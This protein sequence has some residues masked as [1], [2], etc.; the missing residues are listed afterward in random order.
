MASGP[1]RQH[2]ACATASHGARGYSGLS[3]QS[4]RYLEFI[5]EKSFHLEQLAQVSLTLHQGKVLL[6]VIEYVRYTPG[7]Q[8]AEIQIEW[9]APCPVLILNHIP[10]LLQ[11]ARFALKSCG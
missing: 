11:T 7:V 6:N 4:V 5:L 2:S 10:I 8:I 9:E 1:V 3:V